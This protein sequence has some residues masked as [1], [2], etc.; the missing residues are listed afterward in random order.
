MEGLH[1]TQRPE[2]L[3]K[4]VYRE[5]R[6]AMFSGHLQEGQ[7][8]TEVELARALGVS[9]TPVHEAVARLELEGFLEIQPGGLVI[10]FRREDLEEIYDLRQILECHA[11]RLA[12]RRI[13][14]E[15]L[16]QLEEICNRSEGLAW[17]E[18]EARARMNEE[19][20]WTVALASR[21]RR[22]LRLLEE[23]R[24][25]LPAKFFFTGIDADQA[26]RSAQQHRQI[27]R[28]LR[29]R[30]GDRAADVMKEH[31]AH[32]WSLIQSSGALSEFAAFR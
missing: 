31:L 30:D 28:A 2:P 14:A 4:Q 18:G 24:E 17:G 7:R 22:L 6:K 19:F 25:Y 10:T 5:M 29:A 1:P 20:H 27:V 8:T 13:T 3:S 32:T 23:F 15:E 16:A 21:H 9:R 12:A 26:R 11:A